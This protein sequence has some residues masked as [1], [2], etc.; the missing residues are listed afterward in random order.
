MKNGRGEYCEP[1]E[2]DTVYR[3]AYVEG[4]D[5]FLGLQKHCAEKESEA[6]ITPEKLRVE[7]EGYRR[8]L[9]DQLGFPLSAKR[10]KAT[11][12]ERCYVIKD[13]NVHIERFVI[14]CLGSVPVYGILLTQA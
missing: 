8:Q 7:P 13:G 3:S 14:R 6:F 2:R 12:T 4:I 11:L 10:E 5:C 1:L 9:I